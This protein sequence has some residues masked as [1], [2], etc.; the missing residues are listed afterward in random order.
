MW[1]TPEH[2][3]WHLLRPWCPALGI[4]HPARCCSGQQSRPGPAMCAAAPQPPQQPPHGGLGATKPGLLKA[5][6]EGW[7]CNT[8]SHSTRT[9]CFGKTDVST[10]SPS[11]HKPHSASWIRGSAPQLPAHCTP[12][13]TDPL[14]LQGRHAELWLK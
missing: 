3:S 10:W 14:Y 4:R 6:S 13:D 12:Q 11:C 2:Q 9:S 8:I 1:F 5:L 7:W